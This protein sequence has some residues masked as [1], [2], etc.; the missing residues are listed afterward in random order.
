MKH[1]GA[2]IVDTPTEKY[3]KMV[4][5]TKTTKKVRGMQDK[6]YIDEHHAITAI[7]AYVAES[8]IEKTKMKAFNDVLKVRG[9]DVD[10]M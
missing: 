5:I 1:R 7:D 8:F 3:P 2:T 6:R 10:V 4:T 9:A